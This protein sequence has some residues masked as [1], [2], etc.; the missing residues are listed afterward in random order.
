V[1][2]YRTQARAKINLT[3]HV[4]GR[5]LDGYHDL[6]SLVVFAGVN[7]DL[8]F[9]PGPDFALDVTGPM[10]AFC[11][12]IEDN[13]ITKAAMSL[14]ALLPTL[15][16]GRFTLV[17][18]L[19]AQAGIGGGSADAAAALRLL[20]QHHGIA[21]EDA[22]ILEAALRTGADVPVCLRS[23]AQMMRGLGDKLEPVSGLPALFA[24]LVNPGAKVETRAAFARFGLQPGDQRK[25]AAHPPLMPDL[26]MALRASRNDFEPIAIETASMVGEA[27][28]AL[29]EQ[30]GCLLARMSGSGSTCFGLFATC[31][32]AGHAAGALR[33]QHSGWWIKPTMLR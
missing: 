14:Q 31:H 26:M 8:R 27:L 13:L 20:A 29:R 33:K 11:G 23:T 1:P 22:C 21:I 16:L 17:K 24:V 28:A 3:L 19:P 2:F 10:S 32:A 15:A 4:T 30:E 18:R 9:E 25:G 5:R 6:E 12:P 7:D